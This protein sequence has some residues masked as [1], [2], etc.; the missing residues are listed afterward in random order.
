M[1]TAIQITND[2][3]FNPLLGSEIH[4]ITKRNKN[5]NQVAKNI[6]RNCLKLLQNQQ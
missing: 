6:Y 4:L 3:S 2:L 5:C 1:L